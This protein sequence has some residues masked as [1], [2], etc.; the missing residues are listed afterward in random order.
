MAR[1]EIVSLKST[2]IIR[3]LG[4][5]PRVLSIGFLVRYI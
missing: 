3:N 5:K 1:S 2:Q 4:L